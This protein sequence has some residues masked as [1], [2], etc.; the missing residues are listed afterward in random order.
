MAAIVFRKLFV[1]GHTGLNSPQ[2][3]LQV[4]LLAL[5]VLPMSFYNYTFL[6]LRTLLVMS[7]F[8]LD[9]FVQ[10]SFCYD[11]YIN[12]DMCHLLPTS[13]STELQT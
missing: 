12:L 7:L 8:V 13:R 6:S 11:I 9:L 5:H 3:I 1:V 2:M 10:T 4:I